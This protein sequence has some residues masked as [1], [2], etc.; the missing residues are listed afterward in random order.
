MLAIEAVEFARYW[1]EGSHFG[2]FEWVSKNR[3]C[4]FAQSLHRQDITST[5]A[6]SKTRK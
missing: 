3:E 5:W 1:D 6:G 4:G 2:Y